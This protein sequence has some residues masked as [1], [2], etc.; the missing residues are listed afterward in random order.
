MIQF[1]GTGSV[2]REPVSGDPQS[3]GYKYTVPTQPGAGGRFAAS[4]G[5]PT[6][7]Q[8]QH[9]AGREPQEAGPSRAGSLRFS[10]LV[11]AA[12]TFPDTRLHILLR[13]TSPSVGGM[14]RRAIWKNCRL[15]VRQIH[16]D[17]ALRREILIG[18]NRERDGIHRDPQGTDLR[19]VS[20]PGP[21]KTAD[22]PCPSLPS[23]MA[24]AF[25]IAIRLG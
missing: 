8:K 15:G 25:A 12:G 1:H 2:R 20:T 10:V 11:W 16:L 22:D 6:W 5:K 23:R 21:L 9:Q 24:M 3:L 14:K 13:E 4:L 7:M 18:E 19:E 17:T